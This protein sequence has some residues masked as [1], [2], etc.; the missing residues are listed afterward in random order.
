VNEAD[1]RLRGF[2]PSELIG[3]SFATQ[4]HPDDI[5]KYEKEYNIFLDHIEKSKFRTTKI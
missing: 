4:V 3:K 5:V 1:Y 2:L